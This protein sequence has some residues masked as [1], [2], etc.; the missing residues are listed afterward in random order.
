MLGTPRDNAEE[1]VEH[2]QNIDLHISC[3]SPSKTEIITAIK[4]LRNNRSPGI[5]NIAAEILKTDQHLTAELLLPIIR[6]VWETN[7]IP[8]GW[9]KGNIIK[10]PKKGNLT[11]CKN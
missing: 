10:L 8:A 9:K 6:E 1:I 4:S 3:E 7:R 2:P 5:D 11:L